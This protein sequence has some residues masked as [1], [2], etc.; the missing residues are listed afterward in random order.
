MIKRSLI[1]RVC[2]NCKKEDLVRKDGVGKYCRSCRA[3]INSK[4]NIG[5]YI[6]IKG[7]KFGRLFVQEVYCLNKS[8]YWKCLCDCGNIVIVHGNKLRS[9]KTKSCGCITK[10]KNGLS[11]SP[12]YRSWKPMIQ[13]CY[14]TKA[15]SYKNYGARGIKVCDRWKESFFNFLEDM[16][17][18]PQGKSLDRIDP[19]GD[20]EPKNCRWATSKEQ[21]NNKRNNLILEAFGRKQTLQQWADEYNMTWSLLRQRIMREN[22]TVEK[23]LT[24][25]RK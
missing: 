19:L 11:K 22:W 9:G 5:Q 6:D 12:E 15:R 4:N 24:Y 23:A 17:N 3:K 10:A 7:K 25:K 8:Y 18:R 20:Y 16:G 2:P 14:D 21:G 1:L 13:R